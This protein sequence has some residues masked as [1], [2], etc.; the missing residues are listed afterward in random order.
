MKKRRGNILNAMFGTEHVCRRIDF[1][2]ENLN[3]KRSGFKQNRPH[4]LNSETGLKDK[5]NRDIVM[6]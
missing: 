2:P 3:N 6:V 1:K 5:E 4:I